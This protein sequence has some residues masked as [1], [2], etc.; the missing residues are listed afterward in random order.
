MQPVSVRIDSRFNWNRPDQWRC[1]QADKIY[2][3]QSGDM[4]QI[5]SAHRDAVSSV[6]FCPRRQR[7]DLRQPRQNGETLVDHKKE[8]VNKREVTVNYVPVITM[9]SACAGSVFGKS[10]RR[11]VPRLSR[12]LRAP[13]IIS[14]ETSSIFCSSH[15]WVVLNSRGAT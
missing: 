7:T 9:C 15:P 8:E 4:V 3:A 2:D 12:R 6:A 10:R 1:R 14:F 11:W 5:L 13:A